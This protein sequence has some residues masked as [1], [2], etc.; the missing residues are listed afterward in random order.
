ML[1]PNCCVYMTLC[2]SV[3]VLAFDAFCAANPKKCLQRFSG[4]KMRALVTVWAACW[5]T[6][7]L[8][9]SWTGERGQQGRGWQRGAASVAPQQH[10][11][12]M[13]MFW[14][15]QSCRVCQDPSLAVATTLNSLMCRP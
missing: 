8:S 5:L 6:A 11:P 3:H 10:L 7:S 2:V 4:S 14:K 9:C 13:L 1:I 15:L 12:V